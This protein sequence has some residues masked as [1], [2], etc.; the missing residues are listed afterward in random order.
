MR[1]LERT[2]DKVWY[3][4]HSRHWNGDQIIEGQDGFHH[5]WTVKVCNFLEKL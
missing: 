3:W 2:L 5:D 1:K 4:W